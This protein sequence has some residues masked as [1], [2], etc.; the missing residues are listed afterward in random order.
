MRPV[1]SNGPRPDARAR[2]LCAAALGASLTALT[3]PA[4]RAEDIQARSGPGRTAAHAALSD[5]AD[6]PAYPPTLPELASETARHATE[7]T[8]L[9]KRGESLREAQAQAAQRAVDG[10]RAARDEAV[11]R[12]AQTAIAGAVR[13]ATADA[14]AAAGQARVTSARARASGRP[15]HPGARP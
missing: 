15:P 6:L 3:A 9:G 2:W 5:G 7:K 11:N 4:L 14:H 10:G 1:S 8:A 12:A 13:S